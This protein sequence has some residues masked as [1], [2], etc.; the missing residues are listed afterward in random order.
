MTRANYMYLDDEVIRWSPSIADASMAQEPTRFLPRVKRL[1]AMVGVRLMEKDGRDDL[2]GRP[3]ELLLLERLTQVEAG[4]S[5]S[6][7]QMP[8]A[9]NTLGLSLQNA[10]PNA[11]WSVGHDNMNL[12]FTAL[13]GQVRVE[14]ATHAEQMYLA[15][16]ERIRLSPADLRWREPDLLIPLLR[17]DVTTRAHQLLSLLMPRRSL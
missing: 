2:Y 14:I 1:A 15:L 5:R 8:V 6:I 10:L 16:S 17:D 12:S 9:L 7:P 4:S 11:L 3:W 13:E